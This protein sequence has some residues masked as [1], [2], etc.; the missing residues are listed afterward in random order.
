[1]DEN[2]SVCSTSTPRK[3]VG[4]TVSIDRTAIS[5]ESHRPVIVYVIRIKNGRTAWELKKRF[6]D[7]CDLYNKLLEGGL[8]NLSSGK[9]FKEFYQ[10]VEKG[11]VNSRPAMEERKRNLQIFLNSLI[12]DESTKELT[13]LRQFLD[14]DVQNPPSPS[15]ISDVSDITDSRISVNRS[16]LLN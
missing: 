3:P 14:L 7:F 4:L 6:R 9:I 12:S 8:Q 11:I 5:N 2:R 16:R 15:F 13:V 10:Q 1:M